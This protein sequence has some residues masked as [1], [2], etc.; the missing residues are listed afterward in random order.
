MGDFQDYINEAKRNRENFLKPYLEKFDQAK[1]L[2]E[3]AK[4]VIEL[5]KLEPSHLDEVWIRDEVIDWLGRYECMDYIEAAFMSQRGRRYR[6]TEKRAN[7]IRRDHFL[8]KKIHE[9]VEEQQQIAGT[10]CSREV[11]FG[12]LANQ[13]EDTPNPLYPLW[14]GNNEGHQLDLVI[15]KAYKRHNRRLKE[16]KLPIPYYGRDIRVYEK[17]L[18]T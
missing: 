16:R 1:T 10:K 7:Q 2:K 5:I 4:I 14:D 9:I 18:G 12:I 13:Q 3:R 6:L 11:A 15:K 8:V 17:P